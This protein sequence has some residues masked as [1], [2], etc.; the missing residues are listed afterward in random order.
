[1]STTRSTAPAFGETPDW[2]FDPRHPDFGPYWAGCV[3]ERLLVPV[4][5]DGHGFW[6]PRPHC[7]HCFRPTARW[8]ETSGHGSLYS[9]TVIHRTRSPEFAA[10]VPYA[11]GMVTLADMSGIRMVGRVEADPAVLIEGLDLAV[12]FSDL[13]HGVRLPLWRPRLSVAAERTRP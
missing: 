2:G 3:E 9:W 10:Q 11:V 8:V 5:E 7:S 13:Q 12:V 6:P 1:M 4:C